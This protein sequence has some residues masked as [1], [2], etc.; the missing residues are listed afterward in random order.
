[1][2][3]SNCQEGAQKILLLRE[4]ENHLRSYQIFSQIPGS[5]LL[6]QILYTDPLPSRQYH[7]LLFL[8]QLIM[9]SPL[10]IV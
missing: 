9:Q 10:R 8:K 1:M 7:V 3:P 4:K 2:K 6:N 5:L